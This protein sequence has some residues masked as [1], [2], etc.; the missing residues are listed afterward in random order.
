MPE[1]RGVNAFNKLA[2]LCMA[3]SALAACVSSPVS[4]PPDGTAGSGA[5][6][7][8]GATGGG[9]RDGSGGGRVGG[10]GGAVVGSELFPRPISPIIVVLRLLRQPVEL[11]PA[12]AESI[13]GGADNAVSERHTRATCRHQRSDGDTDA[14]DKLTASGRH[15]A[16]PANLYLLYR[17]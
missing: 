6:P 4:A 15:R 14:L 7:S 8:A 13:T 10:S 16:P 1:K 5:E 9:P 11:Q 3:A 12:T 17:R 2:L